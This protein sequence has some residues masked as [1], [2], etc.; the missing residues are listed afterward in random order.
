MI[1]IQ[2]HLHAL[3]DRFTAQSIFFLEWAYEPRIPRPISMHVGGYHNGTI[4][5]TGG[6]DDDIDLY[7]G[8]HGTP[9]ARTFRYDVAQRRWFEGATM[10]MRWEGAVGAVVD[11]TLHVMGGYDRDRD[12]EYY[13]D[14][15]YAGSTILS[16]VVECSVRN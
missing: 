2:P 10:P 1:S 6:R 11:G 9:S 4:V 15:I 3:T 7:H 14:E 12:E 16:Y 13:W 5:V 8:Y